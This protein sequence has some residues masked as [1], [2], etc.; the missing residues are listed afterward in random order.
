MP[1]A[2]RVARISGVVAVDN[3]NRSHAFL[4]GPDSNRG[5]VTIAAADHNNVAA[6]GTLEASENVRRKINA[7]DM[8]GVER[9]VHV[10]PGY[11]D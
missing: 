6:P 4:L 9:P 11:A 8:P 1:S 10:R 7:A 2:S 3:I 5:A